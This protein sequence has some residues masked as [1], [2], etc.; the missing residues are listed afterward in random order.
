MNGRT[1][2]AAPEPG[3][4]PLVSVVI[5]CYNGMPYLPE[6]IAS[7]YAQ[8]YRNWEIILWDNAS[9]D[10]SPAIAQG[11]DLR[12]KYFRGE[13][14][15]PLGAARNLA[16]RQARGEYLCFLDCDDLWLPE[17][18]ARQVQA[19]AA[20]DYA[21]GYAGVQEIDQDGNPIGEYRPSYRSG[22]LLE[23]LL[24]QFDI[25]VP[26][27]IL[28]R[29]A[30]EAA[31]LTFDPNVFA[32]E[33]YCL[34][35]QLAVEHPILVLSEPLAKYRIHSGA[36][37]AKS[38]SRWASERRYTLDLICRDHPGIRER[39]PSAF[40]LAYARAGYYQARFLAAQGRMAEARTELKKL[41]TL[42]FTYFVLYLIACFPA[43][44]W[45][46]IHRIKT[47]RVLISG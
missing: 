47:R 16:I 18:L 24:I 19:M 23:Q 21:L 13:E 32:S 14:N 10:A 11:Y 2:P 26:T 28:R 36:L 8:T 35:M 27:A 31:N 44:V 29:S 37:T 45:N 7:V 30:L 22:F 12:L 46:W 15:V 9:T 40:A 6:A 25:N 39:F 34:F 33:E 3:P 38:V 17:K 5:N 4:Q 20:G 42:T 1:D 43:A 41:R